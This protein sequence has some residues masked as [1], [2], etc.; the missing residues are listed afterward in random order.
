MTVR[1]AIAIRRLEGM[2]GRDRMHRELPA[3]EF[4]GNSVPLGPPPESLTRTEAAVWE[5]MAAAMPWLD[6]THRAV[7][8]DFVRVVINMQEGYAFLKRRKREMRKKGKHV[9][10]A[11][12]TDEGTRPHAIVRVMD[13]HRRAFADYM[14]Q[15]CATPAAQARALEFITQQAKARQSRMEQNTKEF[16]T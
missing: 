1:K 11:N 2:N 4:T 3:V 5:E 6:C 12:L 13:T 8:S 9:F 7:M 14:R 16:L 15:L 10:E